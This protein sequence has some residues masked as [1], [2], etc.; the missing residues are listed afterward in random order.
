MCVVKRTLFGIGTRKPNIRCDIEY[1]NFCSLQHQRVPKNL[2]GDAF[3]LI[4]NMNP[5][6]ISFNVS[7]NHFLKD[8]LM[9]SQALNHREIYSI[10]RCC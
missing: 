9:E 2:L 6:F 10:C 8:I 4:T 1:C 3:N 7:S 5:W